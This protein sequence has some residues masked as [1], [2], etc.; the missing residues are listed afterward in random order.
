MC[1]LVGFLVVWIMR[2]QMQL[3]RDGTGRAATDESDQANKKEIR[4][5]ASKRKTRLQGKEKSELWAGGT[6]DGGGS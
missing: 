3:S 4:A 5:R 1:S 6:G 2:D